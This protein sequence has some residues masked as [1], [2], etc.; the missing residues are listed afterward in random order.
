[1]AHILILEDNLMQTRLLTVVLEQKERHRLTCVAR[2]EEAFALAKALNPDVIISDIVLIDK[3][4]EED[5]RKGLDFVERVK[6]D[7]S[8]AHIPIILFSASP[9][10][11]YNITFEDVKADYWV[12]KPIDLPHLVHTINL[13]LEKTSRVKEEKI[14]A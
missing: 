1:M 2:P 6:T 12:A 13:C 4:L 10:G 5:A 11:Y 7:P 8:L 3:G 14:I 9:L